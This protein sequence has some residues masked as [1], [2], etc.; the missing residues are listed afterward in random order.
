MQ[1]HQSSPV[2]PTLHHQKIDDD[3]GGDSHEAIAQLL[4]LESSLRLQTSTTIQLTHS[5]IGISESSDLSEALAAT[6]SLTKILNDLAEHDE[7]VIL[8]MLICYGYLLRLFAPL[9]ATLE[10]TSSPQLLRSPQDATDHPPAFR[11]GSFSLKSQ[12]ELNA[13]ITSTLICEMMRNLHHSMHKAINSLERQQQQFTTPSS[14]PD[15]KEQ[16][17]SSIFGA[18]RLAIQAVEFRETS[19][20]HRLRSRTFA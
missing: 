19:I 10:N 3:N 9:A 18:A 16:E 1:T 4:R 2:S 5:T 14:R 7:L 13:R 12:P 8:H 15:E 17:P 11:L 20:L 6:E